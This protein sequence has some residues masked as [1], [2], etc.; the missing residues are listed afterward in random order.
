MNINNLERL[1]IYIQENFPLFLTNDMTLYAIIGK[2]VTYTNE[3]INR[4]NNLY[5]IFNNLSD[6]TDTKL[7]EMQATIDT[8]MKE[9]TNDFNNFKTEINT[10][11]VNFRQN[12]LND[13]NTLNGQQLHKIDEFTNSINTDFN[14]FKTSIDNSIASYK[15][16]INNLLTQKD[17]EFQETLNTINANINT[18]VATQINTIL[19]SDS[20]KEI[21][22]S[23]Y[24][25]IYTLA[26]VGNGDMAIPSYS[27]RYNT[28]NNKLYYNSENTSDMGSEITI[29]PKSLYVYN[30]IIYVPT[31]DNGNYILKEL[32]VD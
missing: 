1:R 9:L 32:G 26:Y 17:N 10:D 29:N 31:L 7:S 16:D 20:I 18:E 3:L 25:T 14:N 4:M 6:I 8:F 13:Y 22:S 2:V 21:L 28:T 23:L 12:L 27:Y 24:S 30:T 5:K 11:F 15:E 19:N